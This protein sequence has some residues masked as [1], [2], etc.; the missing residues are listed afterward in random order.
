M[1]KRFGFTLAEMMIVML[2]LTILLAAFT[3]LMTKRKQYVD[4]SSPWKWSPANNSDIYYGMGQNQTVLVGKK[5]KVSFDDALKPRLSIKNPN[6]TTRP[7]LSFQG[8]GD[9]AI[10]HLFIPQNLGSIYLTKNPNNTSSFKLGKEHNTIIG[11]NA[12]TVLE[13]DN[14]SALGFEALRVSKGS[15][16]TAVGVHALRSN[17]TGKENVGV[18]RNA[19]YHNTTGRS[20]VAVGPYSL[21]STRDNGNNGEGTGSYNVAVGHYAMFSNQTGIGNVAIGAGTGDIF[22]NSLSNDDHFVLKNDGTLSS[23]DDLAKFAYTISPNNAKVSNI[24]GLKH[25]YA[26][27]YA[28]GTSTNNTSLTNTNA[29]N[30]VHLMKPAY[31]PDNGRLF[32]VLN[33]SAGDDLGGGAGTPSLSTGFSP[34]STTSGTG[35]ALSSNIKGNYNVAIGSHALSK[36]VYGSWNV[37]IGPGAAYMMGN[38]DKG[39][40]YNGNKFYFSEGNVAIGAKALLNNRRGSAN[41]AIGM[42]ACSGITDGSNKTCLGAGSG[43]NE[44]ALTANNGER[45]NL[46]ETYIGDY[47]GNDTNHRVYVHGNRIEIGTRGSGN[48]IKLNASSIMS[49]V[50]LTRSS[51]LRL[52]NLKGENNDGLAKIRQLKVYNYTFK[53]DKVKTPHVGV[54]AQELRKIFPQAVSEDKSTKEKYLLIRNEDM[55]Y[56]M[57]NAIKELDTTLQNIVK[58]VKEITL[59]IANYDKQI[60]ALQKE[61]KELKTKLQNMEKQNK[62]I[63]NRLKAIESKL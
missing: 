37:A 52:K 51:D 49:N 25:I 7:F 14:N 48:Y 61:N 32:Y 21:M 33:M 36:N 30:G 59:Q 50:D 43:P 6:S 3:P 63:E 17:T 38:K 15:D 34:V 28:T 56:A 22:T 4:S 29:L 42:G 35:G 12:G 60:K 5:N 20:N 23:A 1:K 54:V 8:S 9:D 45:M 44:G 40:P 57:V 11:I 31:D 16:N 46:A 19:L 10:A 62:S 55:F 13:G 58:Q 26:F 41:T 39:A 2:I 53:D 47:P 18:G 27:D 24:S